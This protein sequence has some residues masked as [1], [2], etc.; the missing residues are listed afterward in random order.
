[1]FKKGGR[2]IMKVY[3]NKITGIDDAAVSM[4][5]SKRTWTRDKENELRN[6]VYAATTKEGFGA[7]CSQHVM[8]N[9]ADL[10]EKLIKYGVGQMHTTLLRFIDLSFTVEGLHRAGQDDWDAHTKRMDNRIIRASTRLADFSDDEKSA[11]YQGKILYPSEVVDL[12][13][14]FVKDGIEY[15]LRAF[16]YVRADLSEN[17]DVKRGLYPEAIPSNFVFKVQY[18]E[19]CHIIQFRDAN[20]HAHPEVQLLA[21]E[22]KDAVYSANGWLGDNLTKLQMEPGEK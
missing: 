5:M 1:M 20:G 2:Q 19:L 21:E 12:P 18:P 7:N 15:V 9:Y 11:W 16:G 4:L 13:P 14:V 3:L 22:I 8:V 10:M 17:R 6:L